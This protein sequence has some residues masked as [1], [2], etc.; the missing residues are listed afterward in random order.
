MGHA[1]TSVMLVSTLIPSK[2]AYPA[3]WLAERVPHLETPHAVLARLATSSSG[4]VSLASSIAS[5]ANTVIP[6][7]TCAY[8]AI[9]PARHAGVLDQINAMSA[10]MATSGASPSACQSARRESSSSMVRACLVIRSVSRAS[11]RQMI[12]ATRVP[13]TQPLV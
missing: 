13:I 3:I 12:S 5:K 9:T 11:V 4:L 8:C 6:L 7:Q 2:C 10:Q 1:K